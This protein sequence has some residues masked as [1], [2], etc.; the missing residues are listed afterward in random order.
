MKQ[1]HQTAFVLVMQLC[2]GDEELGNVCVGLEN[3]QHGRLKQSKCV[4]AKEGDAEA[5]S[6]PLRENETYEDLTSHQ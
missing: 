4:K 6:F 5:M 1:C 2:K 3:A